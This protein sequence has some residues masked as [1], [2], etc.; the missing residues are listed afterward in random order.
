METKN[1][2]ISGKVFEVPAP[3]TEGHQLTAGEA[4]QLN[5]VYHENVRNNLAADIKDSI[6]KGTFDQGT[7]Q[8]KVTEYA[9]EYE[10]GVRRAGGPRI[11]DPVAREALRLA[12]DKLSATLREQG[13]K[14]SDYKNL[15]DVAQQ[16]VDKNPVFMERARENIAAR[17]A[18]ATDLMNQVIAGLEEK[19]ADEQAEAA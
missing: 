6:D 16:L 12:V 5:Q 7:W 17:D 13:K 14:P 11:V 9:N 1:I 3:Y 10:M 4:S 18:M 2:T 8:L 19:P 15:K